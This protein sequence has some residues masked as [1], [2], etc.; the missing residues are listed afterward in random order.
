KLHAKDPADRF[1]TAAE[2]AEVL[3]QCLAHVQHPTAVPLPVT[4]SPAAPPRPTR[5]RRWV[6]VGLALLVAG[7]GAAEATGLIQIRAAVSHIF[8]PEGTPVVEQ[9]HPGGVPPAASVPKA[10]GEVPAPV[11]LRWPLTGSFVVSVKVPDAREPVVRKCDVYE[12]F[13]WTSTDPD[14][15]RSI[16]KAYPWGDLEVDA[17]VGPNQH[18]LLRRVRIGVQRYWDQFAG[19]ALR[20]TTLKRE[21][22]L[23]AHDA[24]QLSLTVA[25]RQV[26]LFL[27]KLIGLEQAEFT[28][29][30]AIRIDA[31]GVEWETSGP[32]VVLGGK[33][34]EE[35]GFDTLAEAVEASESGD[36]IEVRGNGPF[37]SNPI[38]L[39]R[40]ALTIRA[41]EGFRPVIRF[42]RGSQGPRSFSRPGPLLRAGGPIVLEGLELQRRPYLNTRSVLVQCEGESV[43][44][45]N[46]RF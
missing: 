19:Y 1:Q 42:G 14:R 10:E 24:G 3:G 9:D 41:A 25:G 44:A 11:V 5:R 26:P 33:G 13:A 6:L 2:V 46:C 43:H 39:G 18:L 21:L 40:S 20:V 27:G 31:P 45:A 8:T 12:V 36:A 7:L 30:G 34:R 32:F 38:D 15:D 29:T 17:R 35:R 28:V 37:E 22:V 16:R 4:E 23:D